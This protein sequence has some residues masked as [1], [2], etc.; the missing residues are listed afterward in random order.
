MDG[1]G[2]MPNPLHELLSQ[3]RAGDDRAREAAYAE[4]VR[5]ITLFVRSG[6]GRRL[7][8]HRESMDVCQSIARS[9]VD[10]HGS[11]GIAFDNDGAII[12][13]LRTV[14]SS[15]LA[16]L[17]RHDGAA[18]RTAPADAPGGPATPAPDH[19]L[20][21][22]EA[23]EALNR[24][25]TESDREVARLRLAGMSW[26]DIG[27]QLGESSQALRKRWSRLAERLSEDLA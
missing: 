20:R 15:K 8:D 4:L 19:A 13:Y 23:R 24:R 22:D 25:F 18:K 5:L 1:A 9:F 3:G 27:A 16:M 11:G 26:D 17:A 12:N 14:V 7:R 6:M 2:A 21:H 10:D